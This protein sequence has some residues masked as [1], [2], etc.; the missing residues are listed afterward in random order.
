MIRY[1]LL[2][3]TI[4]TFSFSNCTSQEKTKGKREPF[5]CSER[6]CLNYRNSEFFGEGD[7]QVK[8]VYKRSIF[9][10]FEDGF[11]DTLNIY[12][13][14]SLIGSKFFLTDPSIGTTMSG[15]EYNYE[16]ERRSPL[17][18]I[19]S[20]TNN[21]CLELQVDERYRILYL[22]H[23]NDGWLGVYSNFYHSYE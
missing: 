3:I 20:V 9:I 12:C 5:F 6:I 13:N 19:E 14:D 18:K 10:M 17:L 1:S 2:L 7:K 8:D 4:L 21:Y 16:K 11:E 15:I 23:N 22:N